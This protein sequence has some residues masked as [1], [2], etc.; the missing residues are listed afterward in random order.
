MEELYFHVWEYIIILYDMIWYVLFW[1][2]SETNTFCAVKGKAVPSY[3][4]KLSLYYIIVL[5]LISYLI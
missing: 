3:C 5:S 4:T 2:N 1:L